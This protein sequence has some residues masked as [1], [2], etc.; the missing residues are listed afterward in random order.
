MMDMIGYEG[1]DDIAI[2]ISYYLQA[3]FCFNFIFVLLI[4]AYHNHFCFLFL[5]FIL[6]LF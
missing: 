5:F 4:H 6:L 2:V 1:Y 3:A